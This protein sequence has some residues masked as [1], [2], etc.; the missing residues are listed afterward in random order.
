MSLV[1]APP[2][3]LD[4]A[5]RDPILARRPI[6]VGAEVPDELLVFE[7]DAHDPEHYAL[8]LGICACLE[9]EWA[10]ADVEPCSAVQKGH[11]SAD[12]C[13]CAGCGERRRI[14]RAAAGP[15]WRRTGLWIRIGGWRFRKWWR[16]IRVALH[17]RRVR[18]ALGT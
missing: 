8:T 9:A 5:Y 15:E 7:I 13:S 11:A 6:P 16:H 17:L 10:G 2:E 18:R 1:I 4:Y 12:T 14:F 3:Y